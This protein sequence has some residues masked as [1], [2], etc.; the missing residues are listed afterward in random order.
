[1]RRI[2]HKDVEAACARYN[3]A[4]GL[5]YWRGKGKARKPADIGYLMWADIR[6]D[7]SNRRGLYAVCSVGGGV[8]SSELRESTMRKTIQAIDLAIKGHRSQAFAVIIRAIHTRGAEQ[9]AALRELNRRG[10][11]LSDE[12]KV[13]AGLVRRFKTYERHGFLISRTAGADAPWR[14]WREDGESFRADTLKGA[15]QMAKEAAR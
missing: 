4:L 9:K 10:L 15:F 12:Q 13:Q 7:G 5:K 14:G 8:C 1:M 2:T 3:K 11:W 6:G